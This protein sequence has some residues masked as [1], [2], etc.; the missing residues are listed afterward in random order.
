MC[1][2]ET[3]EVLVPARVADLLEAAFRAA[4]H[5]AGH[6]LTP[7]ECLL[8]ISRHFTK[9]WKGVVHERSTPERKA[10]RRDEYCRVPGCSRLAAQAHHIIH[11]SQGGTDDP[12]N[13]VGVCAAHHLC[14]H[15]GWVRVSGRAPDQLV[16]ELGEREEPPFDLDRRDA[17][18]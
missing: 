11:V 5:G 17:A 4:Q 13:L 14:I 10:R 1:A 18:A 9:V 6:P 12:W 8:E 15:C 16:W 7:G 3:L 2:R